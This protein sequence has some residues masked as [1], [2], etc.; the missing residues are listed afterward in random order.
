MD[1]KDYFANDK[2]VIE[3]GPED[4]DSVATWKLN[5]PGCV[6]VLWYAPW[7]GYCQKVKD[8]WKKFGAKAAFIK[9]CAFNCEKNK[10]HLAKIKNDMPSLVRGF[11]TIVAYKDGKPVEHHGESDRTVTAF[12]ETARRA[13]RS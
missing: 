11:P 4:F 7:C 1:D 3:L 13:C 12:L 2:H 5:M 6:M 8:E 10:A 9:V